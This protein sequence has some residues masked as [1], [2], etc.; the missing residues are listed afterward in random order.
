MNDLY[1]E[2]L[3]HFAEWFKEAGKK[4]LREP[5]AVC[6]ATA[7]ARGRPSART[8]LLK[9]FDARG[10]VFYTNL[11]SRKGQ[12]MAANPH[13]ALCF[14]WDPWA[15]Q[16]MIEG[17]IQ[18]V[19]KTEAEAYWASRPRASQIG[20]WASLQSAPLGSRRLLQTRVAE[21]LEKFKKSKIPRPEYWSGMRLVPERIEFWVSRPSRLHERTLY[22]A[23]TEGGWTKTLLY[24]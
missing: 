6:L 4:G 13:A 22:S 1:E 20:A 14:Y 18:P 19:S 21:S 11:R 23:Q 9:G 3:S 5:T 15:R 8:V 12:Q 16:V 10:F 24:P 2:A 17:P 7:D